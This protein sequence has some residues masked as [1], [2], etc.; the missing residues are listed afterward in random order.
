MSH[1]PVHVV[2]MTA[3]VGDPETLQLCPKWA[4]EM[5]AAQ[6]EKDMDQVRHLWAERRTG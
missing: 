6:T 4:M 1:A 3:A 5:V 2:I